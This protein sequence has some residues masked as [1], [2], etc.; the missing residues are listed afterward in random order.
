MSKPKR[1]KHLSHYGMLFYSCIAFLVLLIAT[2]IVLSTVYILT[3]LNIYTLRVP[4][5]VATL[6]VLVSILIGVVMSSMVRRLL[7]PLGLIIEAAEKIAGGDYSVRLELDRRNALWELSDS[8]NHMAKELGSIELMRS[9]FINDFSHEFKTPI[10]SIKGFA[11]M[12]KNDSL[13]QEEQREYLDII[14]KES[15]RLSEIATNILELSNLE[16]QSILTD[17][18]VFNLTEQ[19]RVSIVM[20]ENKWEMKKLEINLQC[21]EIAIN[22]NEEMLK[23]VWLNLIDNAVK[24]SPDWEKIE[25]FARESTDE[26]RVAITNKCADL[27]ENNLRHLFDRFYQA[28]ASRTTTGNGLGLPIVKKIVELHGGTVSATSKNGTVTFTVILPKQ[29]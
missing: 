18:K 7:K 29:G 9:D 22:A 23:E 21:D 26:I 28:D 27:T 5:A 13:T 17:K 4:Q 6:C 8:F 2:A 20:L 19:I 1:K 10:I 25:I 24:F 15:D 3:R 12:L 14:I 11:K 16:K